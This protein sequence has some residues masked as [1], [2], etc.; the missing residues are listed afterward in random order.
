MNN[1]RRK[2]MKFPVLLVVLCTILSLLIAVSLLILGLIYCNTN[3]ELWKNKTETEESETE[4]YDTETAEAENFEAVG[5]GI[6]CKWG[7]GCQVCGLGMN[8]VKSNLLGQSTV[9]LS[10]VTFSGRWFEKEINGTNVMVTLNDGAMLYFNTEGTQQLQAHFM[11]ITSLEEPYFVYTVDG[12]NPKR[13]KISQGTIILPDSG[14]H[15]VQIVVDGMNEREDKWNGEIGVAFEKVTGEN[16]KLSPV[17]INRK[18][19]LFM[20]DSITEGIMALRDEAISDYNSATHSFPWYTAK[21][22]QAEP[23]FMGFGATGIVATGSFHTCENMLDYYSASRVIPQAEYPS[24]DLAVIHTGTNDLGVKREVFM[25]GYRKVLEKIH[26]RYPA[27]SIVCIVP[28]TQLHA[29][30][31]VEVTMEYDWCYV[32]ETKDWELTYTDGL[33]PDENGAKIVADK[34]VEFINENNIF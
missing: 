5:Q 21:Q 9:Q 17:E 11:P 26:A 27:I 28:F 14:L 19:I 18:T 22:L 12:E 13:Q 34:L 1:K 20:G 30:E 4:N 25:E 24:C 8:E 16:A 32:L 2:H 15:T 6:D 23:Y 29:E 3:P 31:I 33:H 10:Q 7:A